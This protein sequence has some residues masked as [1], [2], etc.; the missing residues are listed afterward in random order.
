M[1]LLA[2]A[3]ARGHEARL[4]E[5]PQVLHHA[6]ARHRQPLLQRA[7]A[8]PVLPEQLV[9]QAAA[10]GVGEGPEHIVHRRDYR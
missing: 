1:E 2:T 3:P 7:E 4:L 9:E 6:E 8:L 5:H 10:R